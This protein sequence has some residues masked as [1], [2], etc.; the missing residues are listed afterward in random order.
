MKLSQTLGAFSLLGVLALAACQDSEPTA[1][2]ADDTLLTTEDVIALDVL[3]YAGALDAAM[4]VTQGP[5]NAAGHRYG[6]GQAMAMN[7]IAQAQEQ[8]RE[9]IRLME[10]QDSAGALQ[11]SRE[12]RRLMARA[13]QTA[14]GGRFAASLV[15]R[16]EVLA[17]NVA[18]DPGSFNNPMGLQGELNQLATQAR[19]RLHQGDSLGAGDCGLLGE[20]R[21]RQQQ[22][23]NGLGVVSAEIHVELGAEGVSLASDLLDQYGADAEQLEYLAMAEEYLAEAEAALAVQ[24]LGGAIHYADLASWTGLK[25]VVLPGDVT[26]DEVLMIQAL[27]QDLYAQAAAATDLDD[28]ETL[29]L[30]RAEALIAQGESLWETGTI[31]GIGSF[32][33][34][35]VISSW[36]LS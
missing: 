22:R 5:V 4:Q 24:D 23:D 27:A 19:Q 3:S 1:P 33:R 29:L 30:A 31:R 36:I 18:R 9:A 25:A 28:I 13:G 6:H 8:Y 16:L 17:Q 2:L 10:H 14:G 20:Q 35:A 11:Q 12:A 34:A 26:D 15:E 21:Y 7:D 32:W